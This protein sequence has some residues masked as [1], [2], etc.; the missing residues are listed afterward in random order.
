MPFEYLPWGGEYKPAC[1]GQA[2]Y[3]PCV[4]LAVKLTAAEDAPRAVYTKYGEPVHE[5]SC[6][7]FFVSMN[8]DQPYY[9]NFEANANGAFVC[10]KRIDRNTDVTHA[11]KLTDVGNFSVRTERHLEEWSVEFII[12]IKEIKI[13]FGKDG[14]AEGDLIYGNMYKCGD[15]TE[16]PHFISLFPIN[17]PEPDFHRPEFF[18]EFE[19]GKAI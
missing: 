6:L 16:K 10:S 18:G 3:V 12:P 5:D 17:T 15:K 11:D 1:F 19:I 4:G 8:G 7:E 13:F 2:V 9:I 14:L